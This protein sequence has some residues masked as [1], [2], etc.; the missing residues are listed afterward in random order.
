[1]KICVFCSANA[2]IDAV[3][4]QQ[5]RDLGLWIGQQGY[6]LV[7]GGADL[8]LME[9]ISS[10]VIEAGGTTIGVVPKR[11][12]ENGH[13]SKNCSQIL[14]CDSLNERIQIMIRESDVFIALPGGIGTLDEIFA[15]AAAHTIGYHQKSLILYNIQGFW[16]STINLLDDLQ[17]RGMVRKNW[18]DYIQVVNNMSA[19]LSF[20]T[21]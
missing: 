7:Y 15:V 20:V 9:C 5:A 1:M 14:P 13:V 3:F 6:T 21:E 11:L 19:L 17:R 18:H 12:E 4:F 8:G 2:D 16:D 10:A